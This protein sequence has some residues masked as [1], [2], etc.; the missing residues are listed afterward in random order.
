MYR[1]QTGDKHQLVV[2]RALIPDVIKENHNPVYVAHPGVNR[3]YKLLSLNYW[4]PGMRRFI[5][6]YIKKCDSC[7]KRKEDQEFVTPLGEVEEP[8][9]P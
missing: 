3:T 7:Q 1:R 6:D 4:W 2:P 9:T 8:R 5:E